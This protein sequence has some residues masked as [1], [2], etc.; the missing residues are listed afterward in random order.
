MN[1]PNLEMNQVPMPNES[2]P[3]KVLTVENAKDLFRTEGLCR[4]IEHETFICHKPYDTLNI[5]EVA[6]SLDGR[7]S[8]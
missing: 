4:E 5:V 6:V 8:I 3:G 1:A 7:T 2:L